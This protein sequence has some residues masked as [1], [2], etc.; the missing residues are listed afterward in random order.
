[1]KLV[2]KLDENGNVVV[3]NGKVIYVDEDADN[4][5]Y[6]LDPPSMYSKII[7]LGKENKVHRDKKDELEKKLSL[8][9]GIEDIE[10]W[11]KESDVARETVKN[12][13]DKDLIDA[14]KVDEVKAEMK[15][16]YEKKLV[17]KDN[18][19][20][21][22]AQKHNDVLSEKDKNIR[23]LM[24]SNKFSAS[25]HFSGDESSIT[26]IPPDLA[27]SYFGGNFKVEVINGKPELRAYYND[28]EITS[29]LN[30]GEPADFEEAI[31]ILIDKYPRKNSILRAPGGG[32]G[33][34]G[35]GGGG[36]TTPTDAIGK[37]KQQLVE[38][39]KANNF[40]ASIAL[41]NQIAALQKKQQKRA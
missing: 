38:A 13:S 36:D 20:K 8:F 33:G 35:G 16:A 6:P 11:K 3:V 31:S 18:E 29:Q 34:G 32:S 39:Q 10:V 24:I 7:D 41:K 15:D 22:L 23:H 9:D 17:A 14:K 19:I 28:I 2:L 12:F 30:P 27:E 25:P 5:E 1:M 4:K 37:L 40:T 21:A 26:T